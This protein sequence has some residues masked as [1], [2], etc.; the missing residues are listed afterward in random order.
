MYKKNKYFDRHLYNK[1]D[2]LAKK[3]MSDWLK[4]AGYGNIDSEEN[5]GVDISCVK[6]GTNYYFE[7]EIK[8][9]WKTIWPDSWDEIRI[10]YRKKKI[11]DKWTKNGCDGGLTFV[12]FRKD[13]KKAWFM[14][15]ELVN[16]SEVKPVDNK[17]QKGED[18][19][20]IKVKDATLMDMGNAYDKDA[21]INT[22]Y[23]T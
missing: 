22:K 3:V 19:Y 17:F 21:I 20:H 5:Y 1:A 11:I 16:T 15:G 7:T 2:T 23:P 18:F 4:Y 8:Y 12:I 9:G 6:D 14:K 13:C 10:P